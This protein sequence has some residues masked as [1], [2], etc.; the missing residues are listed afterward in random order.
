M[1]IQQKHQLNTRCLNQGHWHEACDNM[2][3]HRRQWRR[4]EMISGP[5]A[6]GANPWILAEFLDGISCR[7][8]PH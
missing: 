4:R 8:V 6:K 5:S 2:S 7:E 3:G 1:N